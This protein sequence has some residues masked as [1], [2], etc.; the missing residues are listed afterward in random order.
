MLAKDS[1]D[2]LIK[3]ALEKIASGELVPSSGPEDVV[4]TEEDK[5]RLHIALARAFGWKE[6]VEE[7]QLIATPEL[8]EK[9]GKNI[10]KVTF[11]AD[12]DFKAAFERSK[13]EITEAE[14]IIK[15]DEVVNELWASQG[16]PHDSERTLYTAKAMA[17][18]VALGYTVDLLDPSLRAV[19]V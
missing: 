19:L 12:T 17:A 4:W 13:E 14:V 15:L 2:P 7:T 18:L 8:I 1:T 11:L 3:E 6:N 16:E 9:V 10:L 5:Q